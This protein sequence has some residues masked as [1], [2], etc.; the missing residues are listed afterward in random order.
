MPFRPLDMLRKLRYT[1]DVMQCRAERVREMPGHLTRHRFHYPFRQGDRY[2][3]W[4]VDM[5]FRL[6]E[7]LGGR[8]VPLAYRRLPPAQ[9]ASESALGRGRARRSRGSPL[10]GSAGPRPIVRK[11]CAIS[12]VDSAGLANRALPI[13]RN[14]LGGMSHDP[15]GPAA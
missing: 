6:V 5:G 7:A 10:R 13:E 9:A 15:G 12:K 1:R 4:L 8:K 11:S 2:P 14:L 3:T